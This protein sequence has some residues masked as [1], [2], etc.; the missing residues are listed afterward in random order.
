MLHPR[1]DFLRAVRDGVVVFEMIDT[2]PNET[3]VREYGAV[4]IAIGRTA[5][6]IAA[7]DGST[8]QAASRYTHVF[9]TDGEGCRLVSAQGTPIA[10]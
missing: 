10:Q 9:L 7:P 6:T 2:D 3:L 4:A 8:I 1:A 5:M